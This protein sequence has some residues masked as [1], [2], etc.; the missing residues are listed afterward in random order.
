V[1]S[2]PPPIRVQSFDRLVVIY[3]RLP[4][5]TE[6][7]CMPMVAICHGRASVPVLATTGSVR[8]KMAFLVLTLHGLGI[9]AANPM[10]YVKEWLSE[11][12]R[13]DN[14]D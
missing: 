2:A 7:R 10:E 8:K 11:H 3:R 14:H 12:F 1:T 13:P 5:L 9:R 6:L 4:L